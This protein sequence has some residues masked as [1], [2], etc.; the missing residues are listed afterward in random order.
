VEAV[1]IGYVSD[2]MD[3]ALADVQLEFV[4]PSGESIEGRSR[5]SG[6]VHADLGSEPARW[7]V[8]L[9]KPGYGRKS[10]EVDVNRDMT[11]HR[12]RMLSDR[13]LGYAWPKWACAGDRV[14]LRVHSPGP[15]HASLW[16]YGWEKR[17]V[18]DI[19]RFESF[20][21]S[22]DRQVVPDGD[23]V[24]TGVGWNHVGR[25]FPPDDRA[26]IEAPDRTGLYFVHLEG[27]DT[28][29]FFSFPLIVAPAR[30]TAAIAVLCSN[31]DWNAYNDFG[32][33]SNY[34]AAWGLPA[35][36]VINPHQDGPFLRDTGGRFWDRDDYDPISFDRPE[37]V[38]RVERD[39]E[40]TDVME[41]IGEEHVA[42]AT[43]RLLGWLERE[44]FVHDVWA[45]TQLHHGPLQ[46]DDYRVVI[47]DQHPEYWSR[48]MYHQLKA[49]VYEHGG[50]LMY[51]GG[52]GIHCEVEFATPTATIHRN[53]DLSEFIATRSF[54]DSP[55]ALVPSRFGRRVENEAT[56]LGVSTTLTGMGTG[57]P[58]RVVDADHWA[59]EGTGLGEG[60]L[61]GTA[62]LDAR[63]PG[64]AS[65][66][67]TDKRNEFTPANA[68]LAAKGTNPENGGSEIVTYDTPSGGEVYSVG[69]ISYVCSLPVDDMLSRITTNVLRRFLG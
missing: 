51:L 34:V 2:E 64:G 63:N 59:F 41:R 13:L 21:P 36:P 26:F 1:L 15:Y 6:A 66:H 30:P 52:N 48:D 68:R 20:G 37:P 14:E 46:L 56:L 17:H 24:K 32:G 25:R 50:R 62:W 55:E 40:I 38:N 11:A 35:T 19:G 3:V 31:I 45:E 39:A 28:D 57:A 29:A 23:F 53:T 69:S 5:A 18:R 54:S 10:V 27:L 65:G 8:V 9:A 67:E 22:G 4:S 16:R 33:R 44:G 7:R 47:L 60:D 61:F 12:F 43:W 49:W 42:P 58:Y